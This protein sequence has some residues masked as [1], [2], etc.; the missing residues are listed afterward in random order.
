MHTTLPLC[1][2]HLDMLL[3]ESQQLSHVLSAWREKTSVESIQFAVRPKSIVDPRDIEAAGS[4]LVRVYHNL[5]GDYESYMGYIVTP[6][7]EV[8]Q[9]VQ[10]AVVQLSPSENQG[11]FELVLKNGTSGKATLS[12]CSYIVIIFNSLTCMEVLHCGMCLMYECSTV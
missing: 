9:V 7:T 10:Q 1:P 11:S 12:V 3:G 8:S 4:G 2:T 6:V 5:Y